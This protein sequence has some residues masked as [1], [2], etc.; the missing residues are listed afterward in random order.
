M[1]ITCYRK[2]SFIH[3]MVKFKALLIKNILGKFLILI[4]FVANSQTGIGTTA[5]HKSSELEVFSTNKGVLLP[6]VTLK[7]ESDQTSIDGGTAATALL[8]Y[9]TGLNPDFP[10]KGFMFWNGTK[11]RLLADANT[12]KAK[13]NGGLM[14]NTAV[15]TPNT[16]T[17]GQDYDGILEVSYNGG[18]GGYYSE[19]EA[20]LYNGLYFKL[21]PGQAKGVG[22]LIF[23]VSGK[24]NVSSP[25]S[26]VNVP[27][28]FLT[29]VLGNMNIGG[30]TIKT[31]NQYSLHRSVGISKG[32]TGEF[33]TQTVNNGYG[34]SRLSWRKDD[35]VEIRS[36][37]LPE[38][39]DYIFSFRLYGSLT[40]TNS[41]TPFYISALKQV[42]PSPA[43][44]PTDVLLDIV[45]LTIIK[46]GSYTFY[47]CPVNL[48]VS[49]QAGDAIYF[50]IAS[51]AGPDLVWTLSNGTNAVVNYDK[52]ANRTSMF[53]WKL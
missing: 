53:F 43:D 5:P 20:Y 16:Y 37:V 26:I 35:D 29:D 17:A 1:K 22:K 51:L 39:G 52:L 49:G 40:G 6:K 24:P 21:Q 41:G 36:I 34:G 48:A 45:E 3:D 30:T 50:K 2:K 38:T 25:N 23:T 11:W 7:G 44:R 13:I 27:I 14:K 47:S 15:L 8:V 19:G 4:G 33:G 12:S 10:T 31:T 32:I 42:G 9:N 46:A 18:N 28:H